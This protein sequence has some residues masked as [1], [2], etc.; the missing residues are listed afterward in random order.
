MGTAELV[1]WCV[2]A[3]AFFP[4]LLLTF[5][6]LAWRRNAA[7][8]Q[9]SVYLL[10]ALV[11]LLLLSGLLDRLLPPAA[12]QVAK[13]LVG[14]WC[15]AV[16][17]YTT[18]SWLAA[19]QRDS[20]LA[21]SLRAGST[22]CLAGGALCLLLPREHQLP[23]SAVLTLLNTALLLWATL[24]AWLLGDRMAMGLVASC[25]LTLGALAGLYAVALGLEPPAWIQAAAA[26]LFV[27]SHVDL[28]AMIWLR[29]RPH[30]LSRDAG[31]SGGA[32]DPVTRLPTGAA[33]V[34]M[35]LRAQARRRRMRRDGA[36]LA[37]MVFGSE[38]LVAQVGTQGMNEV[39]VELAHRF[40]RQVGV[41]N[42][43]GRYWERCFVCL[44][45]TIESP[46][47]LRTLGL[48]VATTL[49]R[50]L[51]LRDREGRPVEVRPDIGVGVL[52]L[53]RRPLPVED[54]LHE[55]E[56]IAQAARAFPSR[57]ATLQP[58]SGEVVAVELADLG[59]RRHRH[60]A[61]ARPSRHPS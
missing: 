33:L 14:P 22:G 41:V 15:S 10:A 20:L 45:E 49:R 46:A 35:L 26:L 17:D 11:L 58:G 28:G 16:A 54:L 5:A 3:G 7:G 6:E 1:V 12:A 13:V 24:R 9:G 19:R 50:P 59:P 48:R 21:A 37:V 4:L 38:Q 25:C 29:S 60:A 56:Q 27:L 8:A 36:I 31:A 32:R 55:A 57:A 30:V 2:A 52:H 34:H 23:A 43:V 51:V 39:F 44:V 42:P 53:G 18:S 61:V 47:W 40:Q